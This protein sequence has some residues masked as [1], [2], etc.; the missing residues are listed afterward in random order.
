[1]S[2]FQGL[3]SD[4]PNVSIDRFDGENLCSTAYFLSHAHWDH[5]QG[6]DHPKFSERLIQNPFI[7]LY[8]HDITLQL[9]VNKVPTLAKLREMG[10]L[11]SVG[12]DE[13]ALIPVFDALGKQLYLC[14]VTLIPA[15]HCPGSVMFLMRRTDPVCADILYT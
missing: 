14:N 12:C 7:K 11:V 15:G 1:M 5:M 6:L 2:S 13:E 10:S 8:T 9:M 3:L 4:F